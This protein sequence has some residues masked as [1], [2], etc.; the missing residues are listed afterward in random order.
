MTIIRTYHDKTGG[1]TLL[2][3]AEIL[4]FLGHTE[5]SWGTDPE[6]LTFKYYTFEEEYWGEKVNIP[7]QDPLHNMKDLPEEVW[8]P[9]E[10]NFGSWGT[11]VVIEGD[12]YA[13]NQ[14]FTHWAG[15]MMISFDASG[16]LPGG[17]DTYFDYW[18]S[19][20]E[21][22]RGLA[23]DLDAIH[24]N[25]PFYKDPGFL[26]V[27]DHVLFDFLVNEYTKRTD[28]VDDDWLWEHVPDLV[29]QWA[30]DKRTTYGAAVAKITGVGD[31]LAA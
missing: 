10:E 11:F 4:V 1:S 29:N 14:L 28:R 30:E 31:A 25:E 7:R 2:N 18:P 27:Y 9:F 16:Y 19:A 8:K 21:G 20:M 24:A 23:I 12:L 6:G 17:D 15:A 3:S 22:L 13:M 5:F 26:G